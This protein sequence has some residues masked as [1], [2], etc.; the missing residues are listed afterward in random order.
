MKRNAKKESK[1]EPARRG[2]AF[3]TME[4]VD[5]QFILMIGCLV[6][7]FVLLV[8]D[9]F[10]YLKYE[11]ATTLLFSFFFIL[12]VS[13]SLQSDVFWVK[14]RFECNTIFMNHL[15]YGYMFYLFCGSILFPLSFDLQFNFDPIFFFFAFIRVPVLIVFMGYANVYF[16]AVHKEG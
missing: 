9:V 12:W 1:K 15:C 5:Q 2:N 14:D 13:F 8:G 4:I 10:Y 16:K 11:V 3:Y 6:S 7:F